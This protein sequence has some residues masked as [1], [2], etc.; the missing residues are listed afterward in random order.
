MAHARGEHDQRPI[1]ISQTIESDSIWIPTDVVTI[2]YLV[3]A[4]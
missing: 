2:A 3:I 1:E 4:L